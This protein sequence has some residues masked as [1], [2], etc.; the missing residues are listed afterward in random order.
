[1]AKKN[2]SSRLTD[3][4]KETQGVLGIFGSKAQSHDTAV[5]EISKLVVKQLEHEF[6]QL[7]FRHRSS[8]RKEEINKEL[9]EIDKELGQV[10]FLSKA[11][12]KPDGGIV[13]VKDDRG[14][15]RVIL[16]SEAKHQGKDIQNIQ[17]GK[18]VGK[19]NDQDLMAAGYAIERSHKNISE[20]AKIEEIS[21][22]NIGHFLIGEAIKTGITEAILKMRLI[23]DNARKVDV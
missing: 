23:I 19:N 12:I 21:E 4:H 11:S 22:V 7:S 20:I 3:Q 10:L 13:E 2:Q 9:Q 17:K 1:M 15:W 18:M 14:K 16:V 5:G 8:I 6:P